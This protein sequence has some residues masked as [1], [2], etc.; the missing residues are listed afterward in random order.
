MIGVAYLLQFIDSDQ[1][2]SY[3]YQSPCSI[4]AKQ[5]ACKN[6]NF[7]FNMEKFNSRE[8]KLTRVN[9]P[10][11]ANF[12]HEIRIKFIQYNIALTNVNTDKD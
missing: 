3:A 2:M 6:N 4:L 8:R 1:Q 7:R 5:L 10:K 12:Q 9:L 11:H